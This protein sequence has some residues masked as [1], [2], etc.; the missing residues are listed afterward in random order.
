LPITTVTGL[1]CQQPN[2][3]TTSA[4]CYCESEVL[5]LLSLVATG[6]VTLPLARYYCDRTHLPATKRSNDIG[7]LL[8]QI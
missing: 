5:L 6:V 7:P 1:T 2:V 8:L 3:A 4:C